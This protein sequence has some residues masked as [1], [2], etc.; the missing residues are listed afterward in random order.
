MTAHG[1][2][3]QD[4][5]GC[6]D[7][8]PALT[9]EA[10]LDLLLAGARAPHEVET[11]STDQALGR[12]LAR[13]LVS[14]IAVPG[15]DNSAMDGYAVCC[16]ELAVG[17]AGA[18]ARLR[19]AQRVAAGALGQPLEPGTAAR[20]FTGAPI[21]PGAD[22]VVI[23]ERCTRD[24]DWVEVPRDLAHGANI[25]R[26]GED[27]RAGVQVIAPGTRLRPAHLGL[28]AAVGATELT[29]YR[30]LRVATFTSGDELVMP[31]QAL[32]PGQIYN[33]NRF[34][35]NGLLAGLGCE[36]KDLGMVP[37][38]LEATMAALLRAVDA[39]DLILASGG[40]SVGE[41]DHVKPAIERLGTLDLWNVAIRPGKPLA[42]GHL[43]GTPFLGSPGNPVSLFVT[44]LIFARPLVLRMQG[45]TGELETPGFKVRA[46]FDSP[47]PD[48]RREFQRARLRRGVDGEW[49]VVVHESRSAGVLSSA[50]WAD[51]LVEIPPGA[52]VAR[53]DPV[54]YIPWGGLLS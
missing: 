49:E 37:D 46:G 26:V 35:L 17:A 40:V 18:P 21:P 29:V 1:I 50:A 13:P 5:P 9:K 15:W 33:S 38:T 42:F 36:V 10:A 4:P 3:N 14:P 19:V 43:N 25:R 2:V 39:A 16:A 6:P 31:G 47:R 51:G 45:D 53:G 52:T 54:V 23:Q 27:L 11:I 41:E 12:V 20:I 32:G 34:M 22:A 30:R 28:A 44:F 8:R 48:R 7:P 24:G